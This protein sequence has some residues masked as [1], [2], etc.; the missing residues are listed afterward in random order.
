[1]CHIRIS[2]LNHQEVTAHTRSTEGASR[3]VY[4]TFFL[5]PNGQ[6][7]KSNLA[8]V[9]HLGLMAPSLAQPKRARR[10][11]LSSDEEPSDGEDNRRNAAAP[12]RNKRARPSASAGAANAAER[13]AKAPR[14][15]DQNALAMEIPVMLQVQLPVVAVRGA[16]ASVD[17]ST[18]DCG[19]SGSGG[20]IPTHHLLGVSAPEPMPHPTPPGAVSIAAAVAPADARPLKH[21][22]VSR[23]NAVEHRVEETEAGGPEVLLVETIDDAGPNEMLDE[24]KR[25]CLP[26]VARRWCL[27]AADAGE[28]AGAQL[29]PNS[30]PVAPSSYRTDNRQEGWSPSF[31]SLLSAM[32]R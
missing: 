23:E 14:R 29:L 32:R 21:P 17:A 18:A 4:D 25:G 13:A 9:R 12:A 2:S 16:A 22:R 15:G 11:A 24:G 6:R 28:G 5:N 8:V 31:R 3:P 26:L 20:L 27:V 19:G 1:M 10:S 7:F 30:V